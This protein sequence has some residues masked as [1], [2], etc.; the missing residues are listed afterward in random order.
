M[1][2]TTAASKFERVTELVVFL[3]KGMGLNPSC[4]LEEWWEADEELRQLCQDPEVSTH[5]STTL[6]A[7]RRM[8]FLQK[9]LR[10]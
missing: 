7:L 4:T 3:K 5:L 2:Q 1:A 9:P 6:A 10:R 8:E